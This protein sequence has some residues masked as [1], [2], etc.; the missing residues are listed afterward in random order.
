MHPYAQKQN[1]IYGQYHY[2]VF[3]DSSANQFIHTFLMATGKVNCGVIL[4]IQ[5]VVCNSIGLSIDN[6]IY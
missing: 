6:Q 3:T 4:I 1:I 2:I 5:K